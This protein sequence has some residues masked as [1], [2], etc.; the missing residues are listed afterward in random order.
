M[1]REMLIPFFFSIITSHYNFLHL[2]SSSALL[3]CTLSNFR[4][5]DRCLTE[6]RLS[7]FQ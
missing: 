5:K 3:L 6:L 2:S 7:H 1:Q 4:Q